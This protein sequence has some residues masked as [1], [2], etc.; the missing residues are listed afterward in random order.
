MNIILLHVFNLKKSKIK[1]KKIQVRQLTH[2]VVLGS[3]AFFVKTIEFI[4]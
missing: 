4:S 1:I 2:L 3:I